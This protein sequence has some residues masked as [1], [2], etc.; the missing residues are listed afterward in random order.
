MGTEANGIAVS[1]VDKPQPEAAAGTEGLL[2][3][4]SPP[5]WK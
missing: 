4:T 1:P 5:T 3:D 2:A